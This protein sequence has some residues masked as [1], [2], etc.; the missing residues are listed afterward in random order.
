SDGTRFAARLGLDVEGGSV[1]AEG[2]TLV[3]RGAD[4]ATLVLGGASAFVSFQEV[5]GDPVTPAETALAATR[6]K[7]AAA[8]EE[9][10]VADHQALY[11]RVKL[12]LGT[13]PAA[14]HPTNERLAPADKRGDPALVTLLF[15]F[16]R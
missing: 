7:T 13:T 14:Q 2:D 6:N 4:A 3:V 8:L 15:N 12:D 16:G 10:H 9:A 1:A 11:R 5:D